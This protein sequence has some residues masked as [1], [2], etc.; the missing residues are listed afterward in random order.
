[1]DRT[2]A[3][4][5]GYRNGYVAQPIGGMGSV[6]RAGFTGGCTHQIFAFGSP[7]LRPAFATGS[8]EC[9]MVSMRGSSR[10]HGSRERIATESRSLTVDSRRV[11]LSAALVANQ[12][13]TQ[14]G[15]LPALLT[16]AGSLLGSAKEPSTRLFLGALLRTASHAQIFSGSRHE[17]SKESLSMRHFRSK[18]SLKE[19]S[20]SYERKQ[21]CARPAAIT[22]HRTR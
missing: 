1:M 14:A 5:G 17:L 2:Q 10:Q 11:Y 6:R 12:G 13:C 3:L 20:A 22:K 15:C 21:F 7:S 4:P 16:K 8:L 9:L 19:E 18:E